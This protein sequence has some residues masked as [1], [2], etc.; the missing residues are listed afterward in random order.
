MS[1]SLYSSLAPL[2]AA[3]LVAGM[4]AASA[5]EP[6]H[7]AKQGSIE[8]GGEIVHCATTDGGSINP[9]RQIPGKVR[10]N[11][12]YA[13]YQYPANQTFKYPDLFNPGVDTPLGFTTPRRPAARAGLRCLCAT[14]SPSTA[15]P[16]LLP[17]GRYRTYLQ[18][19]PHASV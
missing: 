12:A 5:Q 2:T 15:S 11:H 6:L 17:A 13:T 4:A 14:A 7:I 10:I 19:P 1:S 9:T 3:L 18:S 16:G 8:A